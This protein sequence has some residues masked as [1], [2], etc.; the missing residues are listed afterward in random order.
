MIG[1]TQLC[2]QYAWLYQDT[3]AEPQGLWDQKVLDGGINGLKVE[4]DG[5]VAAYI[6]GS[7]TIKDWIEDFDHFALAVDD[8]KVGKVHPGFREGGLHYGSPR[9]F[10]WRG[11]SCLASLWPVDRSWARSLKT[12]RSQ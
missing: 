3:L 6:H 4:P 7:E 2:D 1:T 8:P 10:R 11:W 9:V 5:T 12:P